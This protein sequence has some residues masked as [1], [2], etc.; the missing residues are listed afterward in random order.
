M[1]KLLYLKRNLE[2]EKYFIPII[3]LSNFY[4][5][6]THYYIYG[7]YKPLHYMLIEMLC[8]TPLYVLWIILMI[9]ALFLKKYLSLVLLILNFLIHNK[10]YDGYSN[11]QIIL[12]VDTLLL[13]FILTFSFVFKRLKFK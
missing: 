7:F 11:I 9:L 4:F 1:D 5:L 8:I 10:L 12:F 6:V 2:D 13:V 3:F